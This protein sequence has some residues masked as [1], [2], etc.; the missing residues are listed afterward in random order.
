M[1]NLVWQV[2]TYICPCPGAYTLS[3]TR[4]HDEPRVTSHT[5]AKPSQSWNTIGKSACRRRRDAAQTTADIGLPAV[6][7]ASPACVSERPM[8]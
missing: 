8:L 7:V 5:W 1:L 2:K 6:V 3:Y 4:S